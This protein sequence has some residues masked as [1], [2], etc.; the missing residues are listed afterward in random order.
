MAGAAAHARPTPPRNDPR[1]EQL[2]REAPEHLR[3]E[4]LG[5][6]LCMAPRPRPL[7]QLVAGRVLHLVMGPFDV[8]PGGP[9]GWVLLPEPELALGAAPDRLEPDL[10]GWQRARLPELP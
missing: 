1:V 2:Y 10:A 5:G 3:V 4:V 8:G 6:V 9:G 7:H